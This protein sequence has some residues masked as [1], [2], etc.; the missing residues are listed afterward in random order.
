MSAFRICQ[1][2]SNRSKAKCKQTWQCIARGEFHRGWSNFFKDGTETPKKAV[3]KS[4]NRVNDS[5]WIYK[6][7]VLL[8]YKYGT[9]KS[10]RMST[11]NSYIASDRDG[12]SGEVLVSMSKNIG[13]VFIKSPSLSVWIWMQV[14]KH[15]H[16]KFHILSLENEYLETEKYILQ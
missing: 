12:S 14:S 15:V 1:I 16:S 6:I 2:I 9:G 3:K 11:Q 4:V 10:G 13:V 5:C 7:N 8:I